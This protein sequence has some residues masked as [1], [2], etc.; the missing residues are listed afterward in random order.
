MFSQ[1]IDIHASAASVYSLYADPG[2]WPT[3][4]PAV[5]EVSL[6]AGLR[7]GSTGWLRAR[8]GPR[9]RIRI[10]EA[11]AAQSFT[12][13]SQM[14]G[15]RMIF[16]HTLVAVVGGV[17]ATHTLSFEGPLA[18]VFRRLLGTRIAGT[19]PAALHGLKHMSETD[20]RA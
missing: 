10:L 4:D 9:A 13:A 7:T 11:R 20:A 14:P 1:S 18:F 8:G 2:D 3:W 6:P 15:C 16:G 12:V 5:I 17:R 19:L